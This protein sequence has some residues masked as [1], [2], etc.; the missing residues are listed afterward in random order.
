MSAES[1]NFSRYESGAGLSGAL[2]SLR[3][4]VGVRLPAP[5]PRGEAPASVAPPV[6]R[7]ERARE[8]PVYGTLRVASSAEEPARLE[9]VAEVEE[10]ATWSTESSVEEPPRASA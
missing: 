9:L 2:G 3:T 10:P 6:E 5:L 8:E 4:R 1:S 7:I